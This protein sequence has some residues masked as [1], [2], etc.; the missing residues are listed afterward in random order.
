MPHGKK[1]TLKDELVGLGEAKLFSKDMQNQEKG[2]A[3]KVKKVFME[4]GLYNQ[5]VS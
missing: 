2:V 4:R 1:L 3:V 5:K